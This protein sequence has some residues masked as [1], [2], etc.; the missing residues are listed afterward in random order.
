MKEGYSCH[1]G[2]RTFEN[3]LETAQRGEDLVGCELQQD[4][5]VNRPMLAGGEK[6]ISLED[7]LVKM[8]ADNIESYPADANHVHSFFF[9]STSSLAKALQQQAAK[10]PEF[11]VCVYVY[12]T[13]HNKWFFGAPP[14]SAFPGV[15]KLQRV[16]SASTEE[17]E[18]KENLFE[19]SASR[20][21]EQSKLLRQRMS[22]VSE[23]DE[24]VGETLDAAVDVG[25]EVVE[26]L[27]CMDNVQETDMVQYT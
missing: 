16:H 12:S 17:H 26:C 15:S 5:F 24:D 7:A 10:E 8:R 3:F 23:V 13:R 2:F 19:I 21:H 20:S 22:V 25:V 14:Y 1:L 9:G 6:L 27:A 18:E 11:A 4:S